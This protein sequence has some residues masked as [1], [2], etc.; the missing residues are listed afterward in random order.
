[1]TFRATHQG[2][3]GPGGAQT[4]IQKIIAAQSITAFAD[5]GGGEVTV[6]IV[7]HGLV[8]GDRG[9]ISGTTNY[10][11]TEVVTVVDDDNFKI[12]A[13]WVSDD[14]TGTYT[15]QTGTVSAVEHGRANVVNVVIWETS[16]ADEILPAVSW[17]LSAALL[18]TWDS[19]GHSITAGRVE[20]I[21]Q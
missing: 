21:G 9:V 18:V 17:V 15:P 8:T 2:I 19:G 1:M 12:T 3:P 7:G 10:N 11:A 14:A 6:T 13:T 20:V 5:A 16:G 4:A